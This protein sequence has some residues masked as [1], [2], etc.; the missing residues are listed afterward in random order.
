M[1]KGFVIN[2]K[3]HISM[4][5]KC[6]ITTLVV[7]GVIAG[8]GIA[9]KLIYDHLNEP[10]EIKVND[11]TKDETEEAQVEVAESEATEED[12]V[13]ENPVEE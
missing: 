6:L 7:G 8:A 4:N 10:M 12:F 5:K 2:C 13:E 3:A 11:L 9:A 1:N